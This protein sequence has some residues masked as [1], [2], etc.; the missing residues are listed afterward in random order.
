MAA[1]KATKQDSPVVWLTGLSSAGKTTLATQLLEHL[2]ARGTPAEL[3]DGDI[4]R[5]QFW[6]E[7]GFSQ[8]D[9]MENVRRMGLLASMLSRH[10]VT[11]LVAAISPY[12]SAREE[13]RRII[14]HFV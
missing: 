11:V 9:R 8:A 10:G 12:R 7:L 14:P 5:K 3:L 2:R 4:L 1:Q 13:L 6:P